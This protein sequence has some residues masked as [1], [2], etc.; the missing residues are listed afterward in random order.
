M[1]SYWA[2]PLIR[3]ISSLVVVKISSSL[4][5]L[6]QIIPLGLVFLLPYFENGQNHSFFDIGFVMKKDEIL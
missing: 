5:V 3:K 1:I 6:V 4:P 2:T